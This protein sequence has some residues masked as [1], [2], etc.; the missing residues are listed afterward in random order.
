MPGTRDSR[1]RARV[2]EGN[3]SGVVEKLIRRKGALCAGLPV[4]GRPGGI[5]AA[6]GVAQGKPYATPE[7][8]RHGAVVGT[9]PLPAEVL[10]EAVDP[11]V[12]RYRFVLEET[13]PVV[14]LHSHFLE[15]QHLLPVQPAV[16][17]SDQGAVVVSLV[18]EARPRVLEPG[19]FPACEVGVPDQG[20]SVLGS[21]REHEL[22]GLAGGEQPFVI[23]GPE[24]LLPG[25]CVE[26]RAE[27]IQP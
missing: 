3:P 20:L 5:P 21:R 12:F 23:A 27:F 16:G 15:P 24:R 13:A 11:G 22:A 26:E 4:C 9:Y 25:E 14:A 10:L 7:G 19:G 18:S 2:P 8:N 1:A 6:P 17:A